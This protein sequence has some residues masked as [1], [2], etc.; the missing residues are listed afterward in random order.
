MYL[1]LPYRAGSVLSTYCNFSSYSLTSKCPL[2]SWR[3]Q[4]EDFDLQYE[5]IL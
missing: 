2:Y 1:S 4:K 3:I 5:E